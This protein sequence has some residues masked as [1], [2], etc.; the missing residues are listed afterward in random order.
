VKVK[1]VEEMTRVKIRRLKEIPN[2]RPPI[3]PTMRSPGGREKRI[4][5]ERGFLKAPGEYEIEDNNMI[6]IRIGSR[7]IKVDLSFFTEILIL[8]A[9]NI[10]TN[11]TARLYHGLENKNTT[12]TISRKPANL[13]RASNRCKKVS[14]C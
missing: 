13:V 3:V 6:K 10:H 12:M 14:P 5:L 2:I 7:V 4:I 11:K 1:I 9:S 8:K